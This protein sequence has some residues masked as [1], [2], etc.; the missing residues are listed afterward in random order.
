MAFQNKKVYTAMR[1]KTI[2]VILCLL[3]F[4]ISCSVPEVVLK[5]EIDTGLHDMSSDQGSEITYSDLLSEIAAVNSETAASSQNFSSVSASATSSEKS[6]TSSKK[7]ESKASSKAASKASSKATSSSAP[8]QD[9]LQILGEMR[10]V[11]VAYYE[12]DFKGKSKQEFTETMTLRFKKMKALGINAVFMHARSHSDAFYKSA[13]FPWSNYLTGTQGADPGYDPF[14]VM[15]DLAHNEGLQIHAWV[16]PYRIVTNSIPADM[17]KLADNNPG[18]M[19]FNDGSGDVLKLTNG[20]GLYYNPS[21]KRARELIVNGIKEIINK[22][23]VDGIHFDDYFYPTSDLA[24]DLDSYNKFKANPGGFYGIDFSS[25]KYKNCLDGTKL[26]TMSQMQWRRTNINILIADVYAA[27][28]S[29]SSKLVFGISPA[30]NISNNYNSLALDVSKF[31]STSGFVDYMMPQIYF[32]F[33]HQYDYAKFD[34]MLNDWIKGNTNKNIK[35]YIGLAFYKA[36]GASE[37]NAIAKLEWQ[38]KNDIIMRQ[39]QLIKNTYKTHNQLKGFVFFA[40]TE[41]FNDAV[42]FTLERENLLRVIKN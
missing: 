2:V 29:K 42:H 38:N 32:G 5:N 16:N 14:A 40:Y 34:V 13:Y 20:N 3:T 23:N 9:N 41:L 26:E 25:A 7:A 30:G 39:V 11:W 15:C 17:N 31:L 6:V 12:L 10:G 35:L 24:F 36:G 22:Y 21:S 4:M 28:K 8:S 1:I 33:E 18:K 27:V 19:W 37:S